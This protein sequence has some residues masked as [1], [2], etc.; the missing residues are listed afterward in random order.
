MLVDQDAPKKIN[1][2]YEDHMNKHNKQN[3]GGGYKDDYVFI[4]NYILL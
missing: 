1:D 4:F 3:T 2:I